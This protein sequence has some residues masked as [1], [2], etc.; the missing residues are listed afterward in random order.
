[1]RS[2]QNSSGFTLIEMIL[3]SCVVMTMAFFAVPSF[4]TILSDSSVSSASNA[5]RSIQSAINDQVQ[6]NRI[7]G[8]SPR[9]PTTLDAVTGRRSGEDCTVASGTAERTG[10]T[11]FY[12]LFTDY[13]PKGWSKTSSTTYVYTLNDGETLTYTYT[14][15]EGNGYGT[16]I[17]TGASSGTACPAS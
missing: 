7:S 5:A 9:V 13:W 2:T 11:C 10:N 8:V 14:A 1:M 16:F 4:S 17:C 15:D 3:V 12:D 6:A